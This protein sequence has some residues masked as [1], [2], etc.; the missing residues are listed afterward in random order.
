[1]THAPPVHCIAPVENGASRCPV[2]DRQNDVSLTAGAPVIFVTQ[3]RPN[4]RERA[5]SIRTRLPCM[6]SEEGDDGPLVGRTDTLAEIQSD[7]RNVGPGGTAAVFVTGESGVGKSRLLRETARTMGDAGYSVLSGTCLDIGDASPLHPVLQALRQYQPDLLQWDQAAGADALLDRV[8]RDLRTVAGEKDLLLVLD[9]LQWADRSTRQLLLY[10]LAGLGDVKLSVLAGVRAEALHGA[11]PLRRVLAELR[12]LRSVRVV[13]LAPLDRDQTVELVT[14]IAGDGIEPEDADRVYKRSG[15][16]PFVAEELARDLRDGRVELSDTLRE[17]F[18]S[19]VDELPANAH[20]VVHAVAAGVEPVEHAVLAR[21]VPLPEP[22]LIDAVRAA[23]AHRFVASAADGYRLRHRVVAEILEPEVLRAEPAAWHRRYAE[24]METVGSAPEHARLAH[25][26]QQAGEPARALPSVVAAARS[27]EK[28][29]GFTEAHRYWTLAL[30]LISD[31]A[32]E[33]TELLAHAAES[34]H[35]CGEH[36]RALARLEELA[37]RP[38]AP[39]RCDMHLRRARYLAAAGRSAT[40]EV[41]YERA[42]DAP[43]CSPRQK[44]SAAA[45]LAEL[46]LHLGRYADANT[47]AREAL[48]MAEVNGSTADLVRAS[49]ALGFS[50]AFREDPDAGLAVIRQA[51]TIA[52]RSGHPDDLGVAYLHLAELLTGP[53]NNVE[54]GV[55]VARRGAERLASLGVGRTYQTRLLAI[56]GNGLFR[57]GQWA[58]ADAVLET[59]MRNRPSGADAVELLLARCR[60]WVGFG[61]VDA[62]HRGL[63]AVAT[64]LAG[65]G[66]RYVLPMLTLRAGRARWQARHAEARVAVQRGLTET[67]SDD[68]VLLGVLA[69]HGLR[70]EAEAHAAGEQVDPVAIRRLRTVVDRMTEGV[71]NAASPVRAVIDG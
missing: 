17:I 20:A 60:L 1:M 23:V 45:Y 55:L 58:E 12:R 28:L 71:G 31:D 15:G 30:Q 27:A 57:V 8:S 4:R 25:H 37:G 56:A 62:A 70:A 64:V 61:D 42:L 16:N 10:L 52:E 5:R 39:G 35:Q 29:Y 13:D 53:L 46:L 6:A 19:R 68:L 24:A 3:N 40:A 18:L 41:E 11:H 44:A 59:A 51:V 36:L 26:W 33:R 38:D 32:P 65:G 54:E 14:A 69:W 9:D 2:R 63:A 7:L 67:R 34:A 22:D 48:E 49:A 21:V 66:A 47:R 50:S 43:D